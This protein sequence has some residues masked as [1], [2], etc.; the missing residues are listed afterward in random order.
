MR[1]EILEYLDSAL[2]ADG[3]DDAILGFTDAG[4]VVYLSLIHI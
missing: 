2:F 4:V 1:E 3:F